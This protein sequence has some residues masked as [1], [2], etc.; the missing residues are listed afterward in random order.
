MSA[1]DFQAFQ[2]DFARHIR[3]PHHT[4]RPAGVP[5]RRMAVYNELLFNN[6]T[7]FLDAC[8]PVCRRLIGETRWRRLNR[9]FYRDWRSQTPWFR[10]I[11]HEFVR[12]LNAGIVR[13]PLPA[14]F[15]ELAQYEWA[16]LAVDT[17]DCPTP[18]HDP[19]GDLLRRPVVLNPARL[20][21]ACAWPVHRI[22][23]DYR[24]R[25]PQA[26]QLVVYRDGEDRVRFVEINPVTRR[27]LELLAA[28]PTTG[29]EACRQIGSELR[30]PDPQQLVAFGRGILEDFRARG[31]ILGTRE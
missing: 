24:P 9:S 3:D 2:R 1:P 23:P 16:E 21:L 6:I 30:H 4:A 5:A 20:V 19:A 26:A 29:A 14:W 7:G 25:R 12:Y 18:R 10:E 27:L 28:A 17:M 15:T 8:F 11:P 31:L 22:G 13:Q